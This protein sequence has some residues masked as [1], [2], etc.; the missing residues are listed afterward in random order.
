[1]TFDS[2]GDLW[3]NALAGNDPTCT[4]A[5]TYCL[6]EVN[7]KTAASKFVG[8]AGT[9]VSVTGLAADCEDVLA[10]SRLHLPTLVSARRRRPSRLR[11]C[12]TSS[13]RTTTRRCTSRSTCPGSPSLT[14]LDF[15]AEN[16]L[17]ALANTGPGF[18]GSGIGMSV[19]RIDPSNGNTGAT[20]I[21]VNGAPFVGTMN[22]LGVSPI[23]CDDP[24]PE[25]T[26]APPAPVAAEPL[27]TG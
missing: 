6:W 11:R 26:P 24:G 16:D 25:P 20:D 2:D 18:G 17:W 7:K 3:L 23:S 27:F 8:T 9:G 10:I 1:M 15:D 14:G 13:T 19:F 12:S 4:P 22:G 5:G 21:T